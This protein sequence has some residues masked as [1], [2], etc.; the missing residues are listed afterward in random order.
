MPQKPED[1]SRIIR[2]MARRIAKEKDLF[3]SKEAEDRIGRIPPS[4]ASRDVIEVDLG[5]LEEMIHDIVSL[6]GSIGGGKINLG[7]MEQALKEVKC[8]YLWFC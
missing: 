8:H 6:A 5:K 2:E 4:H 7:E 1:L 3:L